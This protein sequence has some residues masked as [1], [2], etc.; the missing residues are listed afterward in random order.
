M[1]RTLSRSSN[2][3]MSVPATTIT[4][5]QRRFD[6]PQYLLGAGFVLGLL[7]F[8][9]WLWAQPDRDRRPLRARGNGEIVAG[10]SEVGAGGV[11]SGI[12]GASGRGGN[13]IA[14]GDAESSFFE[15]QGEDGE[16]A[17]DA[18]ASVEDAYAAGEDDVAADSMA[19][20]EDVGAPPPMEEGAAL[21]DGLLDAAPRPAPIADPDAGPPGAPL[22][23]YYVEIEVAPGQVQQL[24]LNAESPEHALAILRDFRGDPRILRGPSTTP[25]P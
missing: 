3:R 13:F 17:S 1:M 7:V 25:L 21:T 5:Y 15:G 10:T 24:Q 8:C 6:S 18:E 2:K 4:F 12:T 14:S 23:P 22:L 9:V 16:S 11:L 20:G 19:V